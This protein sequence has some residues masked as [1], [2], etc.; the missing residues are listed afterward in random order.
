MPDDIEVPAWE[1]EFLF[2]LV[3][4][5]FNIEDV[6]LSDSLFLREDSI[7]ALTLVYISS[8]DSVRLLELFEIPDQTF[9]I[10]LPG[11]P[12]TI[13]D[14]DFGG[15]IGLQ[16][17][18]LEAG[19]II[20]IPPIDFPELQLPIDIT[21][22]F[23]EAE[24]ESGFIN[25]SLENGLPV[26]I[27]SGAAVILKNASDNSE[28]ATLPVITDILP[29]QVYTLPTPVSLNNKI[30]EGNL[31]IELQNLSTNGASNVDVLPTDQLSLSFSI[32]DI[33]FREATLTVPAFNFD[34]TDQT[35]E[36]EL[37]NNAQITELVTNSG[38]LSLNVS[39]GNSLPITIEFEFPHIRNPNGILMPA[40]QLENS[41]NTQVDFANTTAD[42]TSNGLFNANSIVLN[43][44]VS[45]PGSASPITIDFESRVTGAISLQNLSIHSVFGYLGY[46]Q[47]LLEGFAEID[48]FD[49]VS[50]GSISFNDPKVIVNISN[51]LGVTVGFLD[52]Q[53]LYVRA[54]NNRLFPGVEVNMRESLT[55]FIIN[56]ATSVGEKQQSQ[57]VIGGANEPSFGEFISLL[58]KQVDYSF[59]I[60]IGTEN[61]D[62]NQ[63]VIDTSQVKGN[64]QI[65]MPLDLQ[66]KDLTITDTLDFDIEIDTE[67]AEF[68]E[69]VLT[70]KVENYFPLEFLL[71]A[72]FMDSLYQRVDSVFLE[73][74][75]I[76]PGELNSEGRVDT[77]FRI[78]YEI[79]VGKEKLENIKRARYIQPE[80]VLNT[81][82]QERVK[83]FNNT[84]ILYKL[85]GDFQVFLPNEL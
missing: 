23:I 22:V 49:Q 61:V 5:A 84:V 29:G 8:E 30:V 79:N 43:V 11:I 62:Y 78:N 14:F 35:F 32:E 25:F 18:G 67:Y 58:P 9:D 54:R 74:R 70:N 42:L 34:I 6:T 66:S 7:G 33:A 59:P 82:S 65:E 39:Y 2:P 26:T 16:D 44:N 55:D 72:Y 64:I 12:N 13:P 47:D 15:T 38:L 81:T 27:K 52:N 80:F 46:Y 3:N 17:L 48:F 24:F 73:K 20:S 83:I 40:I 51:E 85:N 37:P 77:P 31:M 60:F 63:F 68:I 69:G 21:D 50:S 75:L 41:A 45:S 53:E 76:S 19:T 56:G 4:A 57:L 1:A 36:F 71:Q 10:D 28:V